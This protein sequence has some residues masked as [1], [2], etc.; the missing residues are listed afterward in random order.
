MKTRTEYQE[1]L[2]SDVLR[3]WADHYAPTNGEKIILTD[4]FVDVTKGKVIFR[5]HIQ[6]PEGEKP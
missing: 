4:S 5:I 6:E 1:A 2:L 3:F